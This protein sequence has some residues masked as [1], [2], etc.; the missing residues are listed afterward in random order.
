[1]ESMRRREMLTFNASRALADAYV[2]RGM[3]MEYLAI[4]SIAE[5]VRTLPI[6]NSFPPLLSFPPI[7]HSQDTPIEKI[8]ECYETAGDLGL[9]LL[10]SISRS[11][12]NLTLSGLLEIAILR[13]FLLQMSHGMVS[14]TS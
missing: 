5:E 2:Y 10:N 13:S 3:A 11:P 12:L 6:S 4:V 1:M 9:E 7:S 8:V 14:T